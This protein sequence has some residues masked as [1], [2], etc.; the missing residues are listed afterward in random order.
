[1]G[2]GGD[3]RA[4]ADRLLVNR[5]PRRTAIGVWR[6]GTWSA[7]AHRG[8]HRATPLFSLRCYPSGSAG[9]ARGMGDVKRPR[10]GRFT[11]RRRTCAPPAPP[12]TPRPAPPPGS[13]RAS[14]AQLAEHAGQ[15]PLDGARGDEQRLRDLAVGRALRRELS[16]AALAGRQRLHPAQHDAPGP[17]SG[18]AARS[19]PAP[20]AG[21]RPARVATSSASR[22]ARAPRAGVRAPPSAAGSVSARARSRPRRP[23]SVSAPRAAAPRR[24]GRRASSRPLAA[25]P[26]APGA[27]RMP[28]PARAPR[29]RAGGPRLG[30]EHQ[31]PSA[32]SER[33]GRKLGE[34]TS[35]WVSS[36]P[37]A[38]RSSSPSAV[39]P[40]ATA[41]AA[42]KR[43]TAAVSDPPSASAPIGAS[44]CA[45]ASSS[46]CSTSASISTPPFST[47]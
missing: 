3:S 13:D 8:S 5:P 11:S 38:S 9:R 14:P 17:G 25:P 27:R 6:C 47:R 21:A 33:Q 42:A 24:R 40:W 30:A 32:A 22:R 2:P 37:T 23:P 46:P 36:A 18:G 41:T 44:A 16:D 34:V 15:V 28:G 19:P 29:R 4:L 31:L 26:P 35:A 20:P 12:P 45:A 10:I 43:S 7:A 39:R 1:M